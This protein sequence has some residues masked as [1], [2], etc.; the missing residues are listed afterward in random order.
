MRCLT[1]T[2]KPCGRYGVFTLGWMLEPVE[3]L[4]DATVV[5]QFGVARPGHDRAQETLWPLARE[6]QRELGQDRF[7]INLAVRGLFQTRSG[8]RYSIN[9]RAT[10]R[11]ALSCILEPSQPL[12]SLALCSTRAQGE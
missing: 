9:A 7:F 12:R 2:W 3:D 1:L 8:P 10:A 6:I 11:A 4:A 5:E